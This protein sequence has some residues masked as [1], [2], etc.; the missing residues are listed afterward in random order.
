M[1][2]TPPPQTVEPSASDPC[3]LCF[4]GRYVVERVIKRRGNIETL[5]GTDTAT[6]QPVVIKA[7]AAR[8]IASGA[9]MRLHHEADVMRQIDAKSM[10][11]LL[12]VGEQDGMLFLVMPFVAG[13]TL[14]SR[15]QTGP[16]SLAESLRVSISLLTALCHAHEH[17]ILHR[18]I[19]PANIIVNV[20]P[21]VEHA[22]L[23][24]FGLA[25][26]SQLE[27]A[28]HREFVGTAR[29][30]APEQAGLLDRGVAE[31]S[32]LYSVGIVLFECLSGH[33]PFSGETVG[34]VL[35]QHMTARV[36]EL[37]SLGIHVP[38]V[39][40]EAIQRLV[41]KDPTER[42]QTAA[43]A[44]ADLNLAAEALARNETEPAFI[45]GLHDS[46]HT[47]TEP[48][49]VGRDAELRRLDAH[50]E[51]ARHGR[52]G[53]VLVEAESGVGKTR[54]L[55]ELA[56]RTSQNSVLVVRGRL[57]DE[58][59]R[60]PLQALE[61][62]SS[63]LI[64]E[65]AI[66]PG[67]LDRI[68][69]E[70][71]EKQEIIGA[72]LPGLASVMG[73]ET[74]HQAGPEHW[75]ETRALNALTALLDSLGTAERPAIVLLDDCQWADELSLKLIAHWSRE[76]QQAAT[77]D[78][79]V[80][81][82]T[83]F[84]SEEVE[85][86]HPLRKLR[87]LE[88]IEL[89]PLDSA[90]TRK[91]AASMAGTLPEEA[92]QLLERLSEG[93]PFMISA[94]MRG[95][96]ESGAL[97][98]DG[99]GWR[100][101]TRALSD[102]QSSRHAAAFLA[103]R[104]NRFP[105]RTLEFLTVGAVI[106]REFSLALAATLAAL[107][108]MEAFTACKEARR[109]QILWS[110]ADGMNCVFVH[111]RLRL[112]LIARLTDT[113]IRDLHRRAAEELERE[114]PTAHFDLAFH[115]DAAGESVR[116]LPY[117][118]K[119]AEQARGQHSL[120][121]A[122][123][124]YA[125]A[126][127]GVATADEATRYQIAEGLGAI[128]TLQGKYKPAEQLFQ[129]AAFL[130][131]EPAQQADIEGRVGEL[132]QKQGDMKKAG[133]CIERALHLLGERIPRGNLQVCVALAWEL[134]IQTLHTL[135]PKLFL[136]RRKIENAQ[137]E[138]IAIRLLRRLSYAYWFS[139]GTLPT[140]WAHL[141]GMNL[142][143]RYPPTL[144]LA[145][146]YANHGPV[147][148]TLPWFGRGDKYAKK[149]L[150]I[151]EERGDI[152]GR[153]HSLSFRGAVSCAQARFA[154]CIAMCSEAI[155]LFERTGDY[156]EMTTARYQVALSLYRLGDLRGAVEE[157]QR[158]REI[159]RAH[160]DQ[161]A[162]GMPLDVWVLASRGRVPAEIVQSE[163][164]RDRNDSQTTAQIMLAEGVR[165]LYAGQLEEAATMIERARQVVWKAGI[166]HAWVAAISPWLA[167]VRRRQVEETSDRT[168]DARQTFMQQAIRAARRARWVAR[169]FRNEMPHALRESA[170]LAAMQGKPRQARTLFDRSLA[171]AQAQQARHEQAQT[172]Q[173]RGEIGQELGWSS[174]ASDLAQAKELFREIEP[175]A[176]TREGAFAGA[177]KPATLSL[178][179][180]FDTVLEAGREI[181]SALSRDQIFAAVR[182][183]GMRLLRGQTSLVVELDQPGHADS[184]RIVGGHPHEV[185]SRRTLQHAMECRR[186]ITIAEGMQE[187]ASESVLLSGVR[188]TLCAPI[189]VRNKVAGFS[190]VTHREV[191]GL[192][193]EDEERLAA[194][195]AT[196][197]GAALENA[198]GFAEL[199]QLNVTLEQRVARR[200]ADLEERSDELA[201]SNQELEQFAYIASHDLQEPLRTVAS[202][203][204]LLQRRYQ[205]QLDDK[206][207][208]F[209]QT[210]VDGA[211][212]MKTLI[213]NLLEFSRVG[214]Q[215]MEFQAT[216]FADVVANALQSLKFARDESAAVVTQDE[217]PVVQADPDQLTRLMQNLIGNAIKFRS[218]QP[219]QIHVGVQSNTNEWIFLVQDNGIG[220]APKHCDRVF[221]IF[222]RLHG[223]DEYPGTGIGLAVCQKTVVR[224]GGRI[225]VESEFGKGSTFFFSLPKC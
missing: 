85:A 180:R 128:L 202:Y 134:C 199:Q 68:R 82:L 53:L 210:V 133:E 31:P 72:L 75:G 212:R 189:F 183:A 32:D 142:A 83:A 137:T 52:G 103:S 114:R 76:K 13:D 117:A 211:A 154:E 214:T 111:D 129:A 56:Q 100:I 188:S 41:R 8:N 22:T 51:A 191:A 205:G 144:E 70:L 190:Y 23:I 156:W 181:A 28:A 30:M 62:I 102:V 120:E 7:A 195:I 204:Q 165:L 164:A 106:G 88:T 16:L 45:V 86:N 9:A 40:D 104:I 47:L 50:T 175:A 19:K 139:R 95:L 198:Q 147:I 123:Q 21:T 170:L 153:A 1:S 71:A 125:I 11:R 224:H 49:F 73:L 65:G 34:D 136:A 219:P 196:I 130:A 138:F 92:L 43:G 108:P 148:S 208:E 172:L 20:G 112:A 168:P 213:E 46:R 127:R 119:A 171:V 55:D 27:L 12:D 193:G 24:D 107:T 124:Q 84:R 162:A 3:S 93:S 90:D 2:S 200:T 131:R 146:A 160:G 143:E 197:A 48:A 179:D 150:Q 163:L 209:I 177:P 169:S 113:Q 132:A 141:R 157:A 185:I 174:A 201:R 64:A 116:A 122:A 54:L 78:C 17:G 80:L 207:D 59:G 35:R 140:L 91:L 225:W 44:L 216:D 15:L 176:E 5:F 182:D 217:L 57:L 194:F 218:D 89:L 98:P 135:L 63:N 126:E 39:I 151:R 18:D 215:G 110:R 223:R 4:G 118:L 203:C 26:S 42:Y 115:F 105:S 161:Q 25:R 81:L 192:F 166:R 74:R 173:A 37:R 152:W 149:S 77:R 29:Y 167:T 121:I 61:G 33:P 186:P 79:H 14:E 155:R 6:G 87:P 221:K 58:A 69:E 158:T 222:Q 67:L 178:V 96:E 99:D 187:D 97:L 101:E 36:P 206:A 66:D 145:H 38:R 184:Y 109:R 159:G 10:S 94:I 220:I 60:K